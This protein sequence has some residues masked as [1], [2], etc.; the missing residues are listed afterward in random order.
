MAQIVMFGAGKVADVV[1]RHITHAGQHEVVAF[2]VDA[3]HIPPGE[4][5]TRSPSSRSSRSKIAFLRGS[6][7]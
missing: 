4:R 2:T 3:A 7:A 5:F 6:S 1:Y